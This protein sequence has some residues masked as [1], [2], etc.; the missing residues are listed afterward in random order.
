MSADQARSD[1]VIHDASYLYSLSLDQA[2]TLVRQLGRGIAA[3]T[4]NPTLR[5]LMVFQKDEDGV[6]QLG[7]YVMGPPTEEVAKEVE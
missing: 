6:E 3:R 7:F 1:F 2:R 4:E 5:F